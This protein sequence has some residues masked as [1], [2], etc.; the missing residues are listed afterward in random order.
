MYCSG[1]CRGRAFLQRA[2]DAA[3]HIAAL[4]LT[5]LPPDIEDLLVNGSERT[6]Q[7]L[8]IA[9]LGRAPAGAHGYRVGI[10]H[11]A[12]RI[13]RWFPHPRL[14]GASMFLLDPFEWPAVPVAG[15]YAVAYADAAGHAIGGPLF[16]VVI[17]HVDPATRYSD[18]VRTYRPRVK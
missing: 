18:G 4:P 15:S 9:V 6:L 1:R 8:H 14:R 17:E 12:S 16:S 2:Q 5:P 7:A 3:A 10:R 13:V 11:G